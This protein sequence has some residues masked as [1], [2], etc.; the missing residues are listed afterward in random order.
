MSMKALVISSEQHSLLPFSQNWWSFT[1]MNELGQ[2][3]TYPS[4]NIFYNI[5][6]SGELVYLI[7]TFDTCEM[8]RSHRD[9]NLL[10]KILR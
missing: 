8:F 9:A 7:Q 4:P 10:I 5:E 6:I 3:V 2:W 1:G